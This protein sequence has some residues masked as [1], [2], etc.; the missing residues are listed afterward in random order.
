[1]LVGRVID[2]ELGDDAYAPAMCFVD[3]VLGV[4]ERA[5][6]GMDS[7]VLGNVVAVIQPR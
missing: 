4:V 7:G 1:M 3:E 5:V 2:H 6:F